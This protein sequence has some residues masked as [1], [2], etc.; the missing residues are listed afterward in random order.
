MRNRSIKL[1]C[2]DVTGTIFNFKEA[3]ASVYQR[4]AHDSGLVVTSSRLQDSLFGNIK[5]MSSEYPHFGGTSIGNYQW[6]NHVIHQTFQDACQ[7]NY[8]KEKVDEF[9]PKLYQHFKTSDA[10]VVYPDF[11]PFA[12]SLKQKGTK[13]IAI[14]NFDNRLEKIL[15]QLK[16]SP[17]LSEIIVSESAKC[18]KPD[19]GIFKKAVKAAGA[20]VEPEN[21]L[22]IG[23]SVQKDYL[24]AKHVGWN[25]LLMQRTLNQSSSKSIPQADIVSSFEDVSKWLVS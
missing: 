9:A 23:D 18:S 1:I 3:P 15:A 14:S 17:F 22:H 20:E 6:W 13:M 11:F 21:I 2:L 12:T 16:V 8:S 5:K 4:F 10:Y 25:A 7:N 19:P 24:A